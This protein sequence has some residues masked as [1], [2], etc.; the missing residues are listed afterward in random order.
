MRPMHLPG[1]FSRA[2]RPIALSADHY[3]LSATRAWGH[4]QSGLNEAD[5]IA[6]IDQ[7]QGWLS[8]AAE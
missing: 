3:M 5:I 6:A 2:F 4:A 1:S 7:A 8:A